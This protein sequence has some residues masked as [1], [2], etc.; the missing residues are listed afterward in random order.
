MKGHGLRRVFGGGFSPAKPVSTVM[1][2][3]TTEFD[4]E[5][6]NFQLY[7]TKVRAKLAYISASCGAI[8]QESEPEMAAVQTGSFGLEKQ[9]RSAL[10]A[11]WSKLSEKLRLSEEPRLSEKPTPSEEPSPGRVANETDQLGSLAARRSVARLS[12]AA[13]ATLERRSVAIARKTSAT[14]A[15]FAGSRS[16]NGSLTEPPSNPRR[17]IAALVV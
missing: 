12:Q 4:R 13:N 11:T 9:K 15:I 2:L 6:L 14:C 3:F 16:R 8:S 1:L 7:G 10:A 5:N 17:F